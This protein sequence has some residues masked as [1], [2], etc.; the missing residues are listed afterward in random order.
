MERCNS[1]KTSLESSTQLHQ[2][3]KNEN[4]VDVELYRPI[5]G[6]LMHLAIYARPDITFAISKPSQFNYDPSEI[7]FKAVKHVLRYI[8][9]TLDCGIHFSTDSNSNDI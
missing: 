3:R 9:D 6:K 7:H 5:I 4:Q 2:R 8:Q 1:S